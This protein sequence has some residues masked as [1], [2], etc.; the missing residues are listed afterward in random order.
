[1]AKSGRARVTS[2]HTRGLLMG[3]IFHKERG[4]K[5]VLLDVACSLE[6]GFLEE[7]EEEAQPAL[8]RHREG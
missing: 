2:L 5:G 7:S 3:S 8:E 4:K 6:Y 1:M